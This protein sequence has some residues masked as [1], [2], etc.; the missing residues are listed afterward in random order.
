MAKKT[1]TPA[2]IEKVTI[3]MSRP[4]AEAVAKACELYLRQHMGL[5][6]DM[7]DELCMATYSAAQEN[8]SF[9]YAD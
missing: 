7:T 9:S 5:L 3:T 6:E 2:E 8:E 1:K 4:V